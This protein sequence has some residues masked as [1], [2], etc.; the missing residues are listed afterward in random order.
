[1]GDWPNTGFTSDQCSQACKGTTGCTGWWNYNDTSK[2]Y[3]TG[4]ITKLSSDNSTNRTVGV[5]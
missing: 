1:L 5:C 3:L 4:G 2:C